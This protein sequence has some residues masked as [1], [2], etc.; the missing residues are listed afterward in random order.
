MAEFENF[1]TTM[2]SLDYVMAAVHVEEVVF[3]SKLQYSGE[4]DASE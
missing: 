3:D 1:A 4:D 2:R